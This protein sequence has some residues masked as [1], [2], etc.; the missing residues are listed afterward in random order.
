MN[1]GSGSNSY[2]KEVSRHLGGLIVSS[3]RV[4]AWAR[5]YLE[6]ERSLVPKRVT[7]PNRDIIFQVWD[8]AFTTLN[9]Y[10]EY[11]LRFAISGRNV[12]LVP[13]AARAGDAIYRVD[14]CHLPIVLR[15]A[16]EMSQSQNHY[17]IIN[18]ACIGVGSNR[19]WIAAHACPWSIQHPLENLR[20]L[21]QLSPREVTITASF[22]ILP[23]NKYLISK[24]GHLD[25]VISLGPTFFPFRATTKVTFSTCARPTLK[26]V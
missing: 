5:A 26:S 4:R 18:E 10:L 7:R 21:V 11:G 14:S 12:I 24:N 2:M 1:T 20:L 13:S 23:I 6:H 22:Y 3:F 8:D 15:K 16:T 17:N 25:M 19:Q 9:L